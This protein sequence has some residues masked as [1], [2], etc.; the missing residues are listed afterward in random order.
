MKTG[1]PVPNRENERD[2]LQQL[3][4]EMRTERDALLQ[5]VEKA[6][7]AQGRD[8]VNHPAHYTAGKVECI[9]AIESAIVDLIG[10]Q[11]HYTATAIKYLWRWSR[12]GG[13]EDL[14]KARWYIDRLIGE[15]EGSA[16]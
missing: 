13:T 10:I 12:K 4:D 3:I 5:T 9:D 7:D 6:V 16:S 1:T 2:E 14:K 8:P 11:A 15:L